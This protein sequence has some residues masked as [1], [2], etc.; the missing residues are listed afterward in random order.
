[1][2]SRRVSNINNVWP[3]AIFQSSQVLSNLSHLFTL[4]LLDQV[5]VHDPEA[6]SDGRSAGVSLVLGV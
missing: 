1:M 3:G 2:D 5:G 6:L 4:L